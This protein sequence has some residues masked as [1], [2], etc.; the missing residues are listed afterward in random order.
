M[1]SRPIKKLK[2]GTAVMFRIEIRDAGDD[3]TPL[4]SPSTAPTILLR[5]PNGTAIVSFGAM[6]EVETGIYTYTYQ[7]TAGTSAE[8]VWR[9]AFKAVSS[10]STVITP[11]VDAF[12]LIP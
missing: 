3:E 7:T 5:D 10:S 12:E 4:H 6:A 1:A 8:G 2:T 11:E 9:V